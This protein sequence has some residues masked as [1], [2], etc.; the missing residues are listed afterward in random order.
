[1]I[2]ADL[3][4]FIGGDKST[5]KRQCLAVFGIAP[6]GLIVAV[7]VRQILWLDHYHTIECFLPLQ[8]AGHYLWVLPSR[9]HI[10]RAVTKSR[11]AVKTH[12][13]TIGDAFGDIACSAVIWVVC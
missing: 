11:G 9:L 10:A 13:K 12:S 5:I 8:V 1:M 2:G 3:R 6:K 4:A 7:D